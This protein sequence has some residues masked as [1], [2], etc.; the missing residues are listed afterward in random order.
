VEDRAGE[1]PGPEELVER[2]ELGEMLLGIV[3]ELP[4]EQRATVVLRY[5]V[6]MDEASIAEALRCPLGTV[7]WRLH[8]AKG[9]LRERLLLKVRE[10]DLSV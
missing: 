3:Y 9:K 5:Y 6:D 2:G 4:A 8:A 1:G 10:W 7:K